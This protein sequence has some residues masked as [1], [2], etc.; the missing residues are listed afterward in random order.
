MYFITFFKKNAEA[1]KEFTGG[2]GVSSFGGLVIAFSP[3]V[4]LC[5][6]AI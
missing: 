1:A 2:K 4:A 6:I 3:Y 5:G